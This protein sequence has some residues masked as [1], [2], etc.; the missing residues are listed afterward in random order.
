MNTSSASPLWLFGKLWFLVSR[1]VVS[2]SHL[3]DPDFESQLCTIFV[4]NCAEMPSVHQSVSTNPR[5]WWWRRGSRSCSWWQECGC[6]CEWR[7]ASRPRPADI[8]EWTSF[9]AHVDTDRGQWFTVLSVS[10][11]ETSL[12]H[13]VMQQAAP[14]GKKYKWIALKQQRRKSRRRTSWPHLLHSQTSSCSLQLSCPCVAN[15]FQVHS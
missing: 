5:L 7:E 13:F 9:L 8:R 11:A 2:V 14:R 4:H 12:D 3:Q 15:V 6:V 10:S 1:S